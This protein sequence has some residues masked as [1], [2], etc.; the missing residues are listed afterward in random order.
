MDV[1]KFILPAGLIC[2]IAAHGVR[3]SPDEAL[4]RALSVNGGPMKAPAY[5]EMHVPSLVYTMSDSVSGE[6]AVY[7][8]ASAVGRGYMVVSADDVAVPVLGYSDKESFNPDDIPPAMLEWLKGYAEE[9]ATADVDNDAKFALTS[10]PSDHPQ[11]APLV[12]T[13][14]NQG[15]PFNDRC[16]IYF[17]LR[18]VTGCLATAEAQVLNYHKFPEAGSGV[19]SYLWQK[20]N[21]KITVD[22]DTV[23]LMWDDMLDVYTAQSPE[24]NKRAVADLMYACGVVSSMDYSPSS[25]GATSLAGATGMY[26]YMGCKEAS[27]VLRSWYNPDDWDTFIYN[28]LAEKGPLVYCGQSSAG[29]HAFVCDGYQGD[30]YYHFNWGWGGMS[31]GY[32]RLSALNPGSQG[33]GGSSSGY[34]SSQQLVTGLYEPGPKQEFVPTVVADGGVFVDPYFNGVR[35]DTILLESTKEKCGFFNYSMDTISVTYGAR[36]MHNAT[37]NDLFVACYGIKDVALP[38]LRGWLSYPIVLP[39]DLQNG[40]YTVTPAFN[41]NGGGWHEMLVDQASDTYVLMMVDDD[42]VKFERP[43]PAPIEISDIELETALYAG[44]AFKLKAN[45]TAT[46]DRKFY[47]NVA[48]LLGEFYGEDFVSDFQG[49]GV[50]I[51]A[52]PGV[53]SEFEYLSELGNKKL[54]GEYSLVFVNLD[55][56][57]IVSEPITVKVNRYVEPVYEITDAKIVNAAGVDPNDVR[58]SLN[59]KCTAG[60]FSQSLTLA[61][62]QKADSNDDSSFTQISRFESPV[63]YVE[64]GETEAI[65]F[66]GGFAGQSGQIYDARLEIYNPTTRKYVALSDYMPFTVKDASTGI[67]DA[68]L[69]PAD[70]KIYPNPVVTDAVISSPYDIVDV[71]LFDMNGAMLSPRI[72]VSGNSAEI[73]AQALAPGVYVVRVATAAGVSTVRMIKSL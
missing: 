34:N 49:A 47:G 8:F 33:I 41:A 63:P 19:V 4:S 54:K 24:Q 66:G 40:T 27:V 21:T 31:D 6:S 55:N 71:T 56:Y 60:F 48:M 9:I 1:R 11:I 23:P 44:G 68:A 28:Y 64:Q 18:S 38:G 73:D 39:D 37:G 59:L 15:E 26:N 12:T 43:Q 42:S 3:L 7:V 61:V 2:A 5:S 53:V 17:N 51:G 32:F 16:P 70:L 14:W 72:D 46:S 58:V 30:G 50:M 62:G 22:L 57:Q 25:S 69:Q 65:E 52:T 67:E 45:V 29:G 13:L 35:G 36:L 10:E 20:A